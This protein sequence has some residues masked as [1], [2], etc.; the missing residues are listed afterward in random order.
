MHSLEVLNEK[1]LWIDTFHANGFDTPWKIWSF[2]G[3]RNRPVAWNDIVKD[4]DSVSE[5][6][7]ILF[8]DNV[9]VNNS[10]L[11]LLCYSGGLP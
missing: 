5:K 1:A 9:L 8:V 4:H 7:T 3:Y 11:L 10:Y 2:R 6:C